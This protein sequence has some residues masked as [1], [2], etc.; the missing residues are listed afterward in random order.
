MAT[1]KPSTLRRWLGSLA[2]RSIL[3]GGARALPPETEVYCAHE[4]TQSNAR[5]AVTVDPDN[6]ALKQ[7]VEE[8]D[9]MRARNIATVPSTLGEEKRTNPFLRADDPGVA[10]AVGLAG[11]DPVTVFAEVRARKDVFR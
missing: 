9:R 7:R 10:K 4:Y 11:A 3:P 2:I 5:F 8:I 1:R 6:Q